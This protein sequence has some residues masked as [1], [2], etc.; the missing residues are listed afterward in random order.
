M[1]HDD[2]MMLC[3]STLNNIRRPGKIYGCITSNLW[4]KK[5]GKAF[6]FTNNPLIKYVKEDIFTHFQ[7]QNFILG[8]SQNRP[9]CFNAPKQLSHTVQCIPPL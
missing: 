3:L 6:F 4:V 9:T 8:Y 5:K 7:V 2:V 1:Q